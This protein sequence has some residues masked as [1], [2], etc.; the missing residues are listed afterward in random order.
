VVGKGF[1]IGPNAWCVNEGSRERIR[2]GADVICRGV[3]RREAFGDGEILIGDD[4]YIGDDCIVSAALLIEISSGSLLGHGVHVLDNNSHPLAADERASDW[5]AIREGTARAQIAAAPVRIGAQSWI[6]FG[7]SVLK[8]VTIGDRA[9]IAAGSVV[10][11]DVP[12]DAVFAGN[13]A[14]P[15][16][17]SG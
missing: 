16:E 15:V 4:V 9:V 8:G 14:R 7:S 12:A 11:H 6:G 13:P 1:R 10:T 17:A 5:R 3:V 2:I